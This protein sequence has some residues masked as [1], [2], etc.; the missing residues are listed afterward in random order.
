M[1][2]ITNNINKLKMLIA[3]TIRPMTYDELEK[4][5]EIKKSSLK[6]YRHEFRHIISSHV[7]ERKKGLADLFFIKQ[8][9]TILKLAVKKWKIQK[10][11]KKC[12]VN[13][14]YRKTMKKCYYCKEYMYLY[15]D[16]ICC[17]KCLYSSLL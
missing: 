4:L 6:N 14:K 15:K 9:E 5:T 11:N 13:R 2:I 17:K 10:P 12:V 8:K 3:L 1:K 7:R 16:Y